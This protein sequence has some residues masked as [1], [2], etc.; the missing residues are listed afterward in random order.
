MLKSHTHSV[1]NKLITLTSERDLVSLEHLLS[2]SL[3]ELISPTDIGIANTIKIYHVKDAQKQLFSTTVS[4]RN[5]KG[6]KISAALKNAL[7]K[8]FSTGEYCLYQENSETPLSLYP[9]KNSK[10]ETIA[11]IA[12]Q[13]EIKDD[14][15][16]YTIGMVLHV[17][18]NFAGLIRDNE[19]DTLT[20]LLNRKTFESKV[21]KVM[22]LMHKEKSRKDD[23]ADNHFYIAILD[24]DHFKKI[25]DV[26][27]HLIGDEVLLL[28]AQL[29]IETFRERDM[30]FRYGGE[31][32]V[33]VFECANDT[34][35][36]QALERFRTKI[37]TFTFPQVGKV[38]VS[39]GYSSIKEYDTTVQMVERADLALYY[40]KN[41]GRNCIFNYEH[42]VET[43][44]LEEKNNEG[45]VVLF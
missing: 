1:L 22:S 9:L 8:C 35:I 3:F 36:L 26:Y 41:H 38:T 4:E 40:A 16:R 29:M 39:I 6:E 5:P 12:I 10:S 33:G 43:G 44:I 14:E 31:E 23:K 27:G 42:L 20:G 17:Y 25:N 19:H 32:F 34:D 37:S 45:D 7:S 18:Q 30:L 24:I 28:F 15:L 2:E 21:N 13:A 11:V